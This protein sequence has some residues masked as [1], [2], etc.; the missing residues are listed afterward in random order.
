MTSSVSLQRPGDV[1]EARAHPVSSGLHTLDDE[2]AHRRDLGRRREALHAADLLVRKGLIRIVGHRHRADGV[3]PH[4]EN[5]IRAELLLFELALLS[6][7][8]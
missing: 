6:R 7:D 2:T 1:F 3:V 8:R 4:H 5:G